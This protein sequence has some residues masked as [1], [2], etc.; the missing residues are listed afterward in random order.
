MINV[1]DGSDIVQK[2]GGNEYDLSYIHPK[3]EEVGRAGQTIDN[4]K[5]AVNIEVES[6][7]NGIETSTNISVNPAISVGKIINKQYQDKIEDH[8]NIDSAE[9]LEQVEKEMKKNAP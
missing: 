9:V 8:L 6:P 2:S 7:N 5:K 3:F 1:Y 4:N